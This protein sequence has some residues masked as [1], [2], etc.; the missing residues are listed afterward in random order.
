MLK[1]E[2]IIILFNLFYK[3]KSFKIY[4]VLLRNSKKKIARVMPC[5]TRIRII[6]YFLPVLQTYFFLIVPVLKNLIYKN[7]LYIC[8]KLHLRIVIVSIYYRKTLL[9]NV[10]KS[11]KKKIRTKKRLENLYKEK[12]LVYGVKKIR[13]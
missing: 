12:G 11:L 8:F 10:F 5:S 3:V 6:N 7:K 2:K 1:L 9:L 13:R 4:N